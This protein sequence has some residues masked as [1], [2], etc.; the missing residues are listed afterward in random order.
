MS[1]KKFFKF[2]S[3]FF[4]LCSFFTIAFYHFVKYKDKEKHHFI[5]SENRNRSAH[6]QSVPYLEIPTYHIKRVIQRESTKKYLDDGYVVVWNEEKDLEKIG[7]ILL[8]G[9]NIKNVFLDLPKVTL[10]TRVYLYY[11]HFIFIYEVVSKKIVHVTEDAYLED[12]PYPQL[13]LITCTK[14]NQ[15]RLFVLCSLIE[16]KSF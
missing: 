14:D 2:L 15:K 4:F 1:L 9:H 13:S 12:T 6:Y 3:I 8:A 7:N 10:G 5:I 11:K 16:K